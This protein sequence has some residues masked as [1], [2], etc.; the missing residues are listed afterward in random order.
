MINRPGHHG[1]SHQPRYRG[2]GEAVY[3]VQPGAHSLAPW[4]AFAVLCGY[5]A[6]ALATAFILIARRDA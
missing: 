4:S 6:A 2:T 3:R 1:T 5:A